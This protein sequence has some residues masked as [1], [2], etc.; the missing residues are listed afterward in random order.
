MGGSLSLGSGG[1][2]LKSCGGEVRAGR[3]HLPPHPTRLQLSCLSLQSFPLSLLPR[4][5]VI[6]AAIRKTII[7]AEWEELNLLLSH[8]AGFTPRPPTCAGCWGPACPVPHEPGALGS[9]HPAAS[10]APGCGAGGEGG[11]PRPGG[12]H[13][14]LTAVPGPRGAACGHRVSPAWPWRPGAGCPAGCSLPVLPVP[15]APGLR[16]G[17]CWGGWALPGCGSLPRAG[18]SRA[19][20]PALLPPPCRHTLNP[21]L[22]Q[23]GPRAGHAGHHGAASL[24]PPP[25]PPRGPHPPDGT[26]RPDPACAWK[27]GAGDGDG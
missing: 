12:A 3:G 9:S 6:T 1:M 23:P 4:G 14:R 7:P 18:I 17:C 10:T 11:D 25:P 26:G 21:S 16:P 8:F 13:P 20:A 19:R 15:P 5:T 27:I 24:P 2:L 22:T